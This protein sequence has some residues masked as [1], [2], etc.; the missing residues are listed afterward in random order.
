[1]SE[2]RDLTA[3]Q[4]VDALKR[5]GMR[6]VGFMGYVDVGNGLS[7]SIL[8]ANSKRLRVILAFLLREQAKAQKKVVSA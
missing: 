7:V 6:Q 5:H 2:R 3:K 1:M 4:F 8:N